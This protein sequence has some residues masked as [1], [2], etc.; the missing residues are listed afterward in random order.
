MIGHY[1]DYAAWE[2]DNRFEG[3]YYVRQMYAL[4]HGLRRELQDHRG[5]LF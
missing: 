4:S 1:D 3:R 5:I 2:L